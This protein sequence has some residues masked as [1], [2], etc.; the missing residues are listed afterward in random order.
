MIAVHDDGPGI[1]LEEQ[2]R[3]FEPFYRGSRLEA[4]GPRGVGLGLS[5]CQRLIEAH[6][7][8]IGVE[9]STGHGATFNVR[10]PLV[11]QKS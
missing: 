5:I 3:I 11:A 9:S 8:Q 4:Y 7:G 10:L 6:G 2:A 1:P